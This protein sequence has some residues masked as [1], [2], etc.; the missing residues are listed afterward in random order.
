[1][2]AL[3]KSS[4]GLRASDEE[5]AEGLDIA[6]HGLEAYAYGDD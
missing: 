4:M 2:F 5:Q 3:L 1:M 6:E